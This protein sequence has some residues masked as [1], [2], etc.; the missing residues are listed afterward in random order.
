MD[1]GSNRRAFLRGAA[2]AAGLGAV[3]AFS[4]KLEFARASERVASQSDV[5]IPVKLVDSSP[6]GRKRVDCPNEWV[7]P[8]KNVT[9]QGDGSVAEIHLVMFKNRSPLGHGRDQTDLLENTATEPDEKKQLEGEIHGK[10][11][12]LYHYTIVVRDASKK[13]YALDPWLDVE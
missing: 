8:N 2:G 11:S 12:G 3:G 6:P 10:A 7:F 9:W 13:T 5:T 4:S 1:T